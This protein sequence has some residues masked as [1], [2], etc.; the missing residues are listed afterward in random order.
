MRVIQYKNTQGT[1]GWQLWGTKKNGIYGPTSWTLDI[2]LGK[3]I[4]VVIFGRRY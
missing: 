2:F 1:W 4:V 3:R